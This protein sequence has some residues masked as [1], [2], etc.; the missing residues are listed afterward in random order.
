MET[1]ADVRAQLNENE[2]M[3]DAVD[4]NGETVLLTIAGYS[5]SGADD[6]ALA[7][8]L[9]GSIG[10]KVEREDD[11]QI[12]CFGQADYTRIVLKASL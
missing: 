1:L 6:I 10:A 7:E 5:D 4:E 8:S 12:G 3:I 9:L 2:L 11:E